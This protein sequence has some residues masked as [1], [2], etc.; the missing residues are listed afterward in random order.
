M[1]TMTHAGNTKHS[2]SHAAYGQVS[3][4]CGM[5]RVFW[6]TKT[7]LNLRY[8]T[9]SSC[10]ICRRYLGCFVFLVFHSTTALSVLLGSTWIFVIS[11]MWYISPPLLN[12]RLS[13]PG[14]VEAAPHLAASG[15]ISPSIP[16]SRVSHAFSAASRLPPPPPSP[17]TQR[18]CIDL[19]E[20]LRLAT[21]ELSSQRE[22]N[23][24][25]E[26]EYSE[27][28]RTLE[29]KQKADAQQVGV[30]LS[31]VANGEKHFCGVPYNNMAFSSPDGSNTC[32]RRGRNEA[33]KAI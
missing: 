1:A 31:S 10:G 12:H 28:V 22:K 29:Q 14:I 11:P 13:V 24:D 19:T 25:I 17:D 5:V 15:G 6:D 18:L 21:S 27:V 9:Y 30:F 16:I 32:D 33:K 2:G 26:K 4:N 7:G 23:V 8:Y 3:C 20:R